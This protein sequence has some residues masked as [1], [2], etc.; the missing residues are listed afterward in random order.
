MNNSLPHREGADENE[1]RWASSD[2]CFWANAGLEVYLHP[3]DF[4][5]GFWPSQFGGFGLTEPLPTGFESEAG[6]EHDDWQSLLGDISLSL[7][8]QQGL[9]KL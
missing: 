6:F 3:N 9:I 4:Q 5:P 1:A 7:D 2:L 8:R